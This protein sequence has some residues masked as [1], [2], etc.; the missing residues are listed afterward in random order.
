MIEE[1]YLPFFIKEDIF[2]MNEAG[3]VTE[4]PPAAKP[5]SSPESMVKEPAVE[6]STPPVTTP[7]INVP[8]PTAQPLH[9]LAIWTPPL[10]KPDRELL[11]K[12]LA[13]VKEDFNSAF[14]MEGI[15]SYSGNYKRL[16]CFGYQK[17]LELKIG[18]KAELYAPVRID[19]KEI[20]VSAAPTDLHTD[21]AQ[22]KRLW[23]A[24]KVMYQIG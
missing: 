11:V 10:M 20:L 1:D 21:A 19:N 12:I 3:L 2:I 13:A 7:K 18:K 14:V 15:G 4:T 22:K 9:Q 24:L 17:E 16:L 23:E 6:K 8:A 5:V